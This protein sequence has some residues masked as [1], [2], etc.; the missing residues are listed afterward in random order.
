[1]LEGHGCIKDLYRCGQMTHQAFSSNQA[2]H[3]AHIKK[4]LQKSTLS[5]NG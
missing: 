5:S 2:H 3:Q 4:D 1:M